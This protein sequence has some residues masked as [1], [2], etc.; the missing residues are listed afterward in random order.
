MITGTLSDQTDLQSA[1]NAKANIADLGDLATQDTVDYS[2]EVT[3]KPTLGTL[4]SKDT[5]NYETEVTNKPSLGTMASVNDA[6]SDDGYYVRRNGA[7]VALSNLDT[8]AY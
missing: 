6:A 3:N 4:A 2:T 5:V 7:W 8:G 1:L